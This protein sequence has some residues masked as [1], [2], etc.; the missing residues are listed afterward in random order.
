MIEDFLHTAIPLIAGILEIIGVFIIAL[1][2][3]K[4]VYL[5]IKSG[6]DFGDKKIPA[7]LAKAMLLSLSF[8][9]A[10]EIL[11]TILVQSIEELIVIVGIAGLRV[12]LYFVLHWDLKHSE[13]NE[14]NK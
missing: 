14:L 7:E 10:S 3:V 13:G 8:L 1:E 2:G 12:G 5:S 4:A 9:L 6:F 11:L